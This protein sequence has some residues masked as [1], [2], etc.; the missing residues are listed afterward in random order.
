MVSNLDGASLRQ[1]LLGL[2]GQRARASKRAAKAAAMRRPLG[3]SPPS[4]AF[5]VPAISSAGASTG[6]GP[7]TRRSGHD[8]SPLSERADTSD[9]GL[10]R[11]VTAAREAVE[12]RSAPSVPP[13]SHKLPAA[14]R[15]VDTP[16]PHSVPPPPRGPSEK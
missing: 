16:H 12:S 8:L 10:E 5:R 6:G 2:F 13:P 4:G 15:N 9:S 7:T 3:S 11:V 14:S 1:A